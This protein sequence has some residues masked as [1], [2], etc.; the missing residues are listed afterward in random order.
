[1]ED[2]TMDVLVPLMLWTKIW[3]GVSW[4]SGSGVE[5]SDEAGDKDGEFELERML[6]GFVCSL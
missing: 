1:M 4:S 5:R 6:T 2:E 3:M